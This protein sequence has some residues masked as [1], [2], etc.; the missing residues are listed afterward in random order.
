MPMICFDSVGFYIFNLSY[1]RFSIS[2][3]LLF[4]TT[5]SALMISININAFF[6][7]HFIYKNTELYLCYLFTSIKN[8]I[9]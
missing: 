2:H 3:H 7:N 5:L 6:D 4:E 1:I 8:V 9:N